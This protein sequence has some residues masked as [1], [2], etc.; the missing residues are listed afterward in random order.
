MGVVC[1]NY[2]ESADSPSGLDHLMDD[3]CQCQRQTDGKYS[4]VIPK[5][6]KNGTGQIC[7]VLMTW[8]W[9]ID[10]GAANTDR[11]SLVG[12]ALSAASPSCSCSFCASSVPSQVGPV[13]E[14]V[15]DHGSRSLFD[16]P[17]AVFVSCK[18]V[19][20]ADRG[21]VD[22]QGAAVP[23]GVHINL[24]P[25]NWIRSTPTPFRIHAHRS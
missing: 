2:F 19:T 1:W 4:R 17:Q 5:A 14:H 20:Y 15:L 25:V 22:R 9:I 23:G 12:P 11:G 13:E 16:V 10:C 8:L 18:S 21:R 24:V 6:Y 3:M 7:P